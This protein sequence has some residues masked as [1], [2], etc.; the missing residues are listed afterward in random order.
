MK[1]AIAL[2]CALALAAGLSACA[3]SNQAGGEAASSAAA[4]SSAKSEAAAPAAESKSEE[5][6]PAEEAKSEAAASEA[7]PAETSSDSFEIPD[8]WPDDI[9][10]GKTGEEAPPMTKDHLKV[11]FCPTAM[12]TQYQL[13]IDGFNQCLYDNNWGDMIEFVIQAPS[14]QAAVDEQ[15]EIVEGWVQQKFDVLTMCTVNEEALSPLYK[16]ATELGIPIFEFNTPALAVTNPY[17]VCNVGYDQMEAGYKMGEYLCQKFPEEEVAVGIIQGLPGIHNT[18]RLK[19]F[20]Q[21]LEDYH[22]DNLKIVTS[23]PAD[24]VRDKGQ[25]V[26]EN[27]LVSNP[28]IQVIWGMYDEMA[29]GAVAACKDAGR[30]DIMITG[31]DNIPD[32]NEAIHRGDMYATVDTASKQMGY[33]LSQAVKRYCIDGEMVP[34]VW[35]Q[36]CKVY[37][38][39][40][41]DEFSLDNYKFVE[42]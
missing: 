7:A 37:D 5:A 41:I 40:T 20:N 27:M 3:T 39:D 8:T 14:G 2:V 32:A 1:K 13:V 35:N 11:G 30:D 26:T 15:V 23:Q 18:E 16:E 36:E 12:N 34:K 22:G 24:W 9:M 28:E 21:A 29:L 38:V 31:Y 33:A 6:A 42:Y 4:A 10:E 17:Y 19:G 25:T